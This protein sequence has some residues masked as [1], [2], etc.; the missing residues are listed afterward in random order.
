MART[1]EDSIA[2]AGDGEWVSV[3]FEVRQAEQPMKVEELEPQIERVE[4]ILI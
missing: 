3:E 1:P 2:Q 4:S